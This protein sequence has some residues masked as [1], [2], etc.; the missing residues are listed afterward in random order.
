MHIPYVTNWL[1][2]MRPAATTGMIAAPSSFAPR[3]SSGLPRAVARLTSAVGLCLTAIATSGFSLND[4]AAQARALAAKPY[5][6]PAGELSKE[7]RDLTYEQYRDIRFRPE[8]ALW[9]NEGLP[10]ELAFFH[11]GMVF[12][13]PVKI[14]EVTSA[15]VRTLSYRPEDFDFGRNAID[16]TKLG[17]LGFAG[18]R[19]HYAINRPEYTDEVLAFLGASYFRALGKGQVYGLSARGLAIDTA[20]PGGEE[21]P[22]FV[23]YWIERPAPQAKTL[24]IYALLDSPRVTGAYRFVLRPGLE[25]SLEVKARLFL[26]SGVGKLGLAPLSSMYDFGANQPPNHD[27]Y[28]PGTHDSDGLCVHAGND[29]WIW[30]PLV[31]PKRLLVTSFATVDPR[32]FGLQQRD[33]RFSSYEELAARYDLR[34]GAWIEPQ[35]A[36]GAGRVELV[37][38]PTPDETHDNVVAYWVP[39]MTPKPGEPLEL[40]YRILWQKDTEQR[41]PRLWVLQTRRGRGYMPKPDD[42]I[43]LRADFVG[44]AGDAGGHG[45]EPKAAIYADGNGQLLQSLIERNPVAGGW[46]LTL[47]LRRVDPAKPVELRA[48]LYRDNRAISETWSYI[49]PP[50]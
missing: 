12:D 43:W 15:G 11:E 3:S 5:I 33:R 16:A 28:R 4:V 46:R 17:G 24:A 40:A 34:P 48:Y 35:G 39:D 23:E 47:R 37:Q 27:D 18:F 21:F 44:D 29:E 19:V 10:F 45:S 6:K 41:P 14:N 1:F 22:H 20:L 7:L 31:N 25:T 26:R 36:W 9:R 42:S 8:R 49:V 30:R 50:D 2:P 13:Q 38:L 32:G